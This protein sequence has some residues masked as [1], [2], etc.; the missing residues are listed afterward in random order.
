MAK[1]LAVSVNGGQGEIVPVANS[2]QISMGETL[3]NLRIMTTQL[4]LDQFIDPFYISTLLDD[5]DSF[6]C[7]GVT[8]RK[9]A[10]YNQCYWYAYKKIARKLYKV[11]AGEKWQLKHDHMLF[12]KQ[13]LID[14]A[15]GV[16]A[17]IVPVTK[18]I[19]AYDIFDA[20][21]MGGAKSGVGEFA[22]LG[23]E[24]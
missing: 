1:I 10:R 23:K 24:A 3:C 5:I 13:Q 11:Y 16:K 21:V 2:G 20:W 7:D 9:E 17:E 8:Y 18:P 6:H 12:I 4:A 19:T 15:N 14:R 22:D